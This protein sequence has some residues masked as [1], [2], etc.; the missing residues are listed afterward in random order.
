MANRICSF[1]KDLERWT[2]SAK[3]Y[4]V[5]PPFQYRDKDFNHIVAI[6]TIVP[7]SGTETCIFAAD[8][9]GE[10]QEWGALPGSSKGGLDH[11]EAVRGFEQAKDMED[12]G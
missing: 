7:F 3:L 1:V 6:G 12:W 10:V 9:E 2:G 11:N 5:D 4:R 8:A